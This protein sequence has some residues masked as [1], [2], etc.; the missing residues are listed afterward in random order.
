MK[1]YAI[2]AVVPTS[3]NYVCLGCGEIRTFVQGS[4]FGTC[5]YCAAGTARGP[6]GYQEEG[7]EF[8]KLIV[9]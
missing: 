3:G 2:G 8:W 7:V 9:D 5:P 1:L 6:E 4:T